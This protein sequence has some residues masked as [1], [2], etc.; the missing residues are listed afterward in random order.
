[1]VHRVEKGH[2]RGVERCFFTNLPQNGD[3]VSSFFWIFLD[4]SWQK[5]GN[6]GINIFVEVCEIRFSE[7]QVL[8][9]FSYKEE[10]YSAKYRVFLGKHRIGWSRKLF[11]GRF[12]GSCLR[13]TQPVVKF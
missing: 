11:V 6:S 9:S 13:Q 10:L 2:F 7:E 1:M 8:G 3:R 4:F 12:V 5:G